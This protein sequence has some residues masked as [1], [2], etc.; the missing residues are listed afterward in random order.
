MTHFLWSHTA[1]SVWTCMY[2]LASC[3]NYRYKDIFKKY[4]NYTVRV[5]NICCVLLGSLK[6]LR[7]RRLWKRHLKSEFALSQTLSRLF[8]LVQFV[9]CWQIFLELNSK[10]P[11]QSAGKEKESHCRVFTFSTKREIR[12]FHAIVVQ[13]RQ[14][15][16]KKS[17]FCLSNLLLFSW[18][19]ACLKPMLTFVNIAWKK[20]LK[21]ALYN[22]DVII[23]EK[24]IDHPWRGGLLIGC[25]PFP[26]S[27]RKIRLECKWHTTFRV[28]LVENFR[29]QRNDWKGRPGA[30]TI[31]QKIR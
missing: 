25:L 14:G 20:W 7:R 31:W 23:Q 17:L 2:S 29:E 9:K 10:G 16:V 19:P 8:H 30:L 27:F 13:W 22:L 11:R 24:E 18:N 26:K 3:V 4:I 28:V 21:L 5:V 6:Q 12:H 15:N 1:I